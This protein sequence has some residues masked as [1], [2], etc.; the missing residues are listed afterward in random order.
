MKSIIL[1]AALAAL[2]A[3]GQPADNQAASKNV[4]S[5]KPERPPYCFFKDSETKAWKV[6]TDK[7]GNV[8]VSGKVYRQDSRYKA[9]LSPAKVTGT[10][11]EVRP[12]IAANDGAYGAPD[13]WWDVSQTIAN[14]NAVE[15][16]T[17]ECGDKTLA[18][19]AVKRKP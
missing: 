4:A 16:V 8:L 1:L 3:C 15:S 19:L 14:S 2:A 5:A 18:E 9:I 12:T 10:A 13:D 7:S 6:S 11:A 17:V